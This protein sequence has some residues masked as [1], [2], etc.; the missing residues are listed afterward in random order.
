[1][2]PHPVQPKV[3]CKGGTVKGFAANCDMTQATTVQAFIICSIFSYRKDIASLMPV[4][5]LKV[6]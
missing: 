6:R 4:K 5:N 2:L 1:M 3:S